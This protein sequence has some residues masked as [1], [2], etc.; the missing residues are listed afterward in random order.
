MSSVVAALGLY[1]PEACGILVLQ[2]GIETTSPAWQGG[3]FVFSKW[4]QVL[5]GVSAWCFTASHNYAIT[6]RTHFFLMIVRINFYF[7]NWRIIALENFVV[8]CHTSTRISHRCTHVPSFPNLPPTSLH[9]P[10]F[11][12]QSSCLSSLSHIANSHWLF[13]LHMVM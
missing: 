13:I 12:S 7:F 8:F 1:C 4:P 5:F 6:W 11:L 3:F 9:I 10:P 2:P